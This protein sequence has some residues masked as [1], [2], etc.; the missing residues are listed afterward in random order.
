MEGLGSE[1]AFTLKARPE[2]P[3]LIQPQ[4]AG[5]SYGEFAHFRWSQAAGASAYRIQLAADEDFSR[6]LVEQV[7]GEAEWQW[8]LEPGNY[9]WRVATLRSDQDQGPFSDSLAF[10]QR[11]I[12]VSP[13]VDQPEIDADRLSF[14]WRSG[15]VGERYQ[16]QFARDAE[17]QELLVDQVVSEP[18]L[19]FPRPA[20]GLY[21]MRA[22]TLDA[23][24]FAGP[25]GA[26][27]K[28]DVPATRHWLYLLPLLLLIHL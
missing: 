14:A 15:E 23:D 22:R 13:G 28:I 20:G 3:F 24:G 9:F 11:P 26:V 25:F 12:P 4:Q 1:R 8:P 2:A 27:Q 6:P 16:F 19:A 10:T 18:Q 21:Y 5:K 17:F 7:V